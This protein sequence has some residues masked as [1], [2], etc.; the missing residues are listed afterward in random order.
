M[1]C[2]IWLAAS[3]LLHNL[4]NSR[5]GPVKHELE[6]LALNQTLEKLY[7]QSK[8]ELENK[9]QKNKKAKNFQPKKLSP[10]CANANT[11]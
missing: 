5:I 4:N 2:L 8:Y 1:Y 7:A 6:T 11:S 10:W 3:L 9:K